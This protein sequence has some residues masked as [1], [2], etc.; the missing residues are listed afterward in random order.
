MRFAPPAT[1]ERR[2]EVRSRGL[3]VKKTARAQRLGFV[4]RTVHRRG[5]SPHFSVFIVTVLKLSGGQPVESGRVLIQHS[6]G[7]EMQFTAE[8]FAYRALHARETRTIGSRL[9]SSDRH[10][11][12]RMK[13]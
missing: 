5:R 2:R 1:A 8:Q 12:N 13:R 11:L 4:R 7:L 6:A 9:A 10:F 3:L